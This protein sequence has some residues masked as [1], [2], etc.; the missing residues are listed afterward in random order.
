MD[1]KGG[2]GLQLLGRGRVAD[3]VLVRG[4]TRAVVFFMAQLVPDNMVVLYRAAQCLGVHGPA[5]D[6]GGR[7]VSCGP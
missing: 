7:A 3:I 5:R 2:P 4:P 1:G 6:Q